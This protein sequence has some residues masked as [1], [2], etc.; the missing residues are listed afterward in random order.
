M[1]K[2][3]NSYFSFG[4]LI[5][6]TGSHY[7]RS[8]LPS[9][10]RL[11]RALILALAICTPQLRAQEKLTPQ[12]VNEIRELSAATLAQEGLPGLS[13]AVS[14]G[15]QVWSAGFGSAD[16]EQNVPVD[17]RSMFRTASISK[18]MTAA[19]AMRLAEDGKLNIDSPIQ[20]YCPQ[21]PAKQWTITSRELMTQLSGIRHY[22]GANGEAR[23][24]AAQRDALDSLVKRE[25]STQYTR[26]T[27]VIPTL[28]A[29]KDDPLVY[30]PGTHFL[31]S[32][33]GYRV[34]GC[35]L[36]GAAQMPY[37]TLMRN[38][39]FTPAGMITIT[40]DDSQIITP[41]RVAGYAWDTSKHLVRAPFRDV[42]ENLP[43]G[44]HLAT[45]EDLVRFA[46]AFNSGK[47]I[48]LK[49]RDL[50]LQHPKLKNGSDA[51]DAPPFFGMGTGLYYG[52]GMFVGKSASGERLLMHTG[53]DPGSSTELLLA[54]D[55]G[56]AIAVMSNVSQWDGTDA[57]A[58]KILEIVR[59]E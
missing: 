12:Q 15:D 14:N 58:K 24:T 17:S 11:A 21:Y 38:L 22:H 40:E 43:G 45:P 5:V 39:V 18:W 10:P 7:Q 6:N 42:S 3:A 44:G 30:E 25:Q 23:D 1:T 2:I 31:Y 48:Q 49:T 28:D 8:S 16:L 56:I 32:S 34:L 36:E 9:W 59:T 27:E 37:R 55:G 13:V 53:R 47:L 51:P 35:V 50:M 29:F 20:H 46:I 54:P 4:E 52:M 57:L 19:A 33:L 26:Y 41:H